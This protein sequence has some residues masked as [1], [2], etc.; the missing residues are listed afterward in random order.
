MGMF[1]YFLMCYLQ[2]NQLCLKTTVLY[3][4]MFSPC[5]TH[6]HFLVPTG[7]LRS[8]W[9][10]RSLFQHY[11]L[12]TR[13]THFFRT[14]IKKKHL[15]TIVKTRTCFGQLYVHHQGVRSVL[16]WNC[17]LLSLLL[18]GCFRC[19]GGWIWFVWQS[20]ASVLHVVLVGLCLVDVV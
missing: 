7:A 17:L 12:K 3:L 4:S 1:C 11:A 8:L 13:K 16:D 9:F 2:V 18:I 15:W 6:F 10:V 19:V 14:H 5:I 20:L